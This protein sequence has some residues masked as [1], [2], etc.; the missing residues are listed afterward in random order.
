[1]NRSPPIQT[2][3]RGY[4]FSQPQ[5][6]ATGNPGGSNCRGFH[7]TF[8]AVQIDMTQVEENGPNAIQN[9]PTAWLVPAS[10]VRVASER[11]GL[12]W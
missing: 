2:A 5:A 11:E 4:G 6:R 10:A 7:L 12:M 8:S 3:V 9:T 1:M